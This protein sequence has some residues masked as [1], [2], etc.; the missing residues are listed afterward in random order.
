MLAE[1]DTLRFETLLATSE[2]ARGARLN[3]DEVRELATL[4]RRH[5]AALA[6]LREVGDDPSALRHLNALCVRAH[7]LLYVEPGTGGSRWARVRAQVP[8]VVARTWRAQTVAWTLLLVGVTVGLTLGM[9][10]DGAVHALVPMSM[11]S[12]P[13]QFDRLMTSAE[14]RAA[15]F[16]RSAVPVAANMAFGSYLFTHNTKV[17]LL[18]FVTGMLAGVPT[19]LLI[20][21]NGLMLGG[22][23]A[24]FVRDA[25]P[26]SY[27]AW[28]L[29]H[30]V[31]ELTA[32]TTCSA[33]GLVLGAAIV[34]PG[35]AG[36]RRALRDAIAPAGLLFAT[37]LP[38]F[39]LAAVTESFVRESLLPT[40]VRLAVAGA[41]AGLLVWG[42]R[43]VRRTAL[44]QRPDARWIEAL[45]RPAPAR[46]G[47]D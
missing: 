4:Y 23:S 46:P 45:I 40:G 25:W 3:L 18:A 44:R 30:G 41:Y 39:A 34:M 20:L 9:R 37:S 28:I 24:I 26:I 5:V 43:R 15:F 8:H 22:F 13:E 1:G 27:L 19:I 12:G 2:R 17:G 16:E 35:R 10:D 36:L 29:P 11:C 47:S 31:P 21:Y 33:A 42:L 6:R 38:L 7:S 32:I 14:A